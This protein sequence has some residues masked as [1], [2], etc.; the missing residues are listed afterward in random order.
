M[1]IH[2]KQAILKVYLKH[3][4]K[5]LTNHNIIYI[6]TLIDVWV[7]FSNK[8]HKQVQCQTK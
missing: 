6:G 7:I 2:I 8:K 1:I 4:K 3:S 5:N